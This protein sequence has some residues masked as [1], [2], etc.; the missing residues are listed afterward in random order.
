MIPPR[1]PNWLLGRQ[2]ARRG[3]PEVLGELTELFEARLLTHGRFRSVLWYWMQLVSFP[4]HRLR[5]R[6]RRRNRS[7]VATLDPPPTRRDSPKRGRR[8][9][10][11]SLVSDLCYAV[12]GLRQTPGFAVV[13]V[14][15]MGLG[16]GANT[17]I[18]SIV[19]A[20]L[21]RP[22]P[23]ENPS[24]LVRL[25]A[26]R[27]DA[28]DPGSF[29]YP[30]FLDVRERRDLFSGAAAHAAMFVSLVNE[31]GSETIFAEYVS[32]DFFRVLGLAPSR[33]RSFDAREDQPGAAEP[34]AIV[35][36]GVWER[37]YG[38]DPEIVG[39]TVR[40]NGHPV[41][42]IGVGPEG[43]AGTMVGFTME[44]W[45][46]WGT[47]AL[48]DREYA[49]MLESRASRAFSVT[50]RLQ[51]GVNVAQA[52]AGIDAL[53]EGLAEEHPTSNADRHVVTIPSNDVR[54]HPF[55]DEALY[56]V[57]S[58]LMVVVGLVLVVACTNLANLLLVRASSRRREVAV[59]L[60]LGATRRRLVSQLLT[61][62]TLLGVFGG[63]VGLVLAYW[64][65]NLI[66]SF[67]PPISVPIAV[68]LPVDGT[69]LGFTVL[70]SI[71]TGAVFG[72]VPA[73]RASRPDV[74]ATLKAESGSQGRLRRGFGLANALVVGQ[75]AVSLVLLIAA[76]LF[77]RGLASAQRVD[78]GFEI[79]N[80]A[81]A[82]V[83]LGL[84]G[85]GE[86]DG[87]EFVYELVRRLEAHPGVIG[88]A[89]ADRIPLGVGMQTQDVEFEGEAS[90]VEGEREADFIV[91]SPEYFDIMDVPILHGRNFAPYDTEGGPA[92]V[93][94]SAAMARQFWGAEDVV[95]RRFLT[96]GDPVEIVGVARDTKVR[97]LAENVRAQFY[98][99]FSQSPPAFLFV[100]LVAST[101]GDP[102]AMPE[103]FRREVKA[104][105]PDV[106]L[107]EAKT[108]QEHL[109]IMLYAPR[110]AAVLLSA[111]GGLAMALAALGLYGVVGYSVA[112]RTRE[113]GIRVA[114][115]ADRGRVVGMVIREG[116]RMVGA[117]LM[118]G[119]ALSML[120]MRPIAGLLHGVPPT[121][122]RTFGGVAILLGAV[123][124]LAS[125]VPARRAAGVDPMEAL[126]CE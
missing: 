10:F 113:V 20:V 40:L 39:S 18:F 77:L 9:V 122:T 63:A 41:T 119:I 126:R 6:L 19:N 23:Y 28:N 49:R 125:Y 70:L 105:D 79:E 69:V 97:T 11:G 14:T 34:V 71:A 83:G 80:T 32:A 90:G 75:V 93:I 86:E 66:T 26:Q 45:V 53:W 25:F 85:F 12:R 62:S 61:E 50:A 101:N 1:F 30:D 3:R 114:L 81:M 29:S 78:P 43:F 59:R 112:Q 91:V 35:S 120:A 27:D 21:F 51:P 111:F 54:L 104:L 67:R 88:V 92:V 46:P 5:D 89:I 94:V 117:G 15:I 96:G 73:L 13:A 98:L 37:R 76:G 38:R 109:G 110:M 100:S 118:L 57:A 31:E 121:D 48:V 52:A 72:L 58:L 17:A 74:V 123:A 82:T 108:M 116:M 102:A 44:F 56:P 55:I 115:G 47:A 87:R 60:A 24:E 95:G 103:V 8:P 65:A 4:F 107:F 2:F 33:G 124:L 16:I 36:H 22:L 42:I 99:P 68:D 64:T 7:Q 106:P 84:G